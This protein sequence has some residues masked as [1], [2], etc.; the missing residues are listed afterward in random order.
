MTRQYLWLVHVFAERDSIES[1]EFIIQQEKI[2]VRISYFGESDRRRI[3][4]R[5]SGVRKLG[6]D[7]VAVETGNV[8][9]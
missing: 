2:C 8:D 9:T 4:E 3:D 6:R 7:V 1:A 5:S